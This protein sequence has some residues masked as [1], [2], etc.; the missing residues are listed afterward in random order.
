[1]HRRAICGRTSRSSSD[2]EGPV[3]VTRPRTTSVPVW[4]PVN[5]DPEEPS[6]PGGDHEGPAPGE[7]RLRA[8]DGDTYASWDEIYTDNV[9]RLSRLIY[10]KVG[11]R[12]TPT[13]SPPRSS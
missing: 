8:V 7:R 12:P 13:P 10:S 3:G 9:V 6:P 1:M 11:N 2:N 5:D 4:R